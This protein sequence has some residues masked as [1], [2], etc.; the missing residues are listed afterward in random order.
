ML[1]KQPEIK[2]YKDQFE[3]RHGKAKA[4]SI[5]AQRLGRTVYHMLKNNCAF[6]INTFLPTEA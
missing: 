6:D 4:L 1:R 2:A 5:L 3:Q